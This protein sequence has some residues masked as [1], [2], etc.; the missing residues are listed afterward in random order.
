MELNN[1]FSQF[2]ETEGKVI[3]DSNK[4]SG[5]KESRIHYGP[6]DLRF[7]VK[8]SARSQEQQKAVWSF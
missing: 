3:M 8:G 4:E 5:R 1:R 7:K 6:D 2:L